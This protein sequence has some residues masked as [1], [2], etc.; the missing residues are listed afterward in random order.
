MTLGLPRG[1]VA[2]YPHEK[3]WENEADRTILLLKRIHGGDMNERFDELY[4]NR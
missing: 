2:L 3:A 1:T 4:E